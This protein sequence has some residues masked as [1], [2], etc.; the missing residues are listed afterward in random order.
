[1]D[2]NYKGPIVL[3]NVESGERRSLPLPANSA[4]YRA[5]L[6]GSNNLVCQEE[7]RLELIE[8]E[9]GRKRHQIDLSGGNTL[10]W[11]VAWQVSED[12]KILAYFKELVSHPSPSWAQGAR[13]AATG[14][15]VCYDLESGRRLGAYPSSEW[16]QSPSGLLSPGGN[17]VAV[18]K[19]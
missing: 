9:S 7:K 12:G 16:L 13:V 8:L 19:A 11:E 3:W 15:V 2:L 4:I 1:R 17:L 6:A 10:P 18:S 5:K 14:Q